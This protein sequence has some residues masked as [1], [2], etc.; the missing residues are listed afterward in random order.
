MS[1]FFGSYTAGTHEEGTEAAIGRQMVV[2]SLYRCA[3]AFAFLD[4]LE[5]VF[6]CLQ[7]CESYNKNNVNCLSVSLN[8]FSAPISYP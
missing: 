6:T 1:S 3:R 8:S 4:N 5:M 7:Q 2:K